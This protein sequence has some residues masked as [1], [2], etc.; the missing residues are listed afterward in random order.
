MNFDIQIN[1]NITAD[2][3][4]EAEKEV[5]DIMDGVISSENHL[6]SWDFV[7][8]IEEDIQDVPWV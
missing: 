7:E 4:L 5:K 3:E 2:N 6:N 8:Y 1:I